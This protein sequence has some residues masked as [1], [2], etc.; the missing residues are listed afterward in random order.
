[1]AQD[2]SASLKSV[3]SSQRQVVA[4]DDLDFPAQ[5]INGDLLPQ[6][7]VDNAPEKT[8][9]SQAMGNRLLDDGGVPVGPGVV[10]DQSVNPGNLVGGEVGGSA[11]QEPCTGGADLVGEDLGLGEP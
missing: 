3:D 11:E 6:R 8:S 1:M 4:D 10:G 5:H 2:P 7:V 9:R